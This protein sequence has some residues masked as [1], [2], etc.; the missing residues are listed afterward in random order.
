MHGVHKDAKSQGSIRLMIRVFLI[1]YL[2]FLFFGY[3]L[4]SHVDRHERQQLIQLLVSDSKLLADAM[5]LD[6]HS[7]MKLQFHADTALMKWVDSN[8]GE[9]DKPNWSQ[10]P[11][12]TVMM[13][14]HMFWKSWTIWTF[15]VC[16]R[17][18]AQVRTLTHHKTTL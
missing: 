8:Q 17:K 5:Q 16:S 13:K 11:K 14:I 18:R 2:V 6:F 10:A 1:L 12:K 7:L 3:R 9:D 4:V 15:T